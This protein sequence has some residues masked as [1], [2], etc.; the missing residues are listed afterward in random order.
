[1]MILLATI[2][3]LVSGYILVDYSYFYFSGAKAKKF[4][5]NSILPP[6]LANPVEVLSPADSMLGCVF[7]S[8]RDN[9]MYGSKVRFSWDCLTAKVCLFDGKEYGPVNKGV[10]VSPENTRRYI[11]QCSSGD[12]T[13]VFAKSIGVFEFVLREISSSDS[14]PSI[15]EKV[16]SL[17]PEEG[18]E[19][20]DSDT[21]TL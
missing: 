15:E 10:E 1:M 13:E 18:A 21:A 17:F 5:T 2:A 20:K 16:N 9:V 8:S 14:V 12:R 6:S 4:V 11:L 7:R 3:I 19:E